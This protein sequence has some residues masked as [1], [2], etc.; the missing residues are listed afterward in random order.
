M[1]K[2]L[3]QVYKAFFLAGFPAIQ[4]RKWFNRLIMPQLKKKSFIQ[5]N[6]LIAVWSMAGFMAMGYIGFLATGSGTGNS[7]GALV[8]QNRS[9]PDK[10]AIEPVQ[11]KIAALSARVEELTNREKTTSKKLS[12][13]EE[14]LIPTASLPDKPA[15]T[16]VKAVRPSERPVPRAPVS[17]N[18]LP[19]TENDKITELSVDPSP[20]TFGVDLASARSIESL[21]RHWDYLRKSRPALVKGLKPHFIDKGTADLP[22]YSLVLGPFRQ[23]SEARASCNALLRA[24]I[25]CQETSL[26]VPSLNKIHTADRGLSN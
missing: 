1:L 18:V 7:G 4:T 9:L 21:K 2:F 20:E 26:Q 17:V 25:E 15:Q 23:M 10:G 19:L 5:K 12:I 16:A 22:L 8:A 24:R 3:I 11:Q 13:I 6:G 14:A